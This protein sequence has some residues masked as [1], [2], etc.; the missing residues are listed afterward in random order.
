[1][2]QENRITTKNWTLYD[3]RHVVFKP[4]NL[5]SQ[6]LEQGYNWA[7]KEFYKWSNIVNSSLQ[8]NK[9]KHIIKHFAYTG[10]WK[11]FEK[12]WN[13]II[14]TGGLKHMLPLLELILSEVNMK[15]QNKVSIKNLQK[16]LS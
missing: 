8:H 16:S 7:Y 9:I 13:L 15:S 1:M 11:K 14:Q 2:E 10:G 5:S 3:T 12:I 6:D 4:L